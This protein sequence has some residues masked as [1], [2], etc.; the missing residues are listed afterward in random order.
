MSYGDELHSHEGHE[1]PHPVDKIHKDSTLPG[2]S[3]VQNRSTPKKDIAS[4]IACFRYK[5]GR[6]QT[7]KQRMIEKTLSSDSTG[8]SYTGVSC[9]SADDGKLCGFCPIDF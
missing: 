4:D 2:P 8:I 5:D 6:C 1:H 9:S 3:C 7:G